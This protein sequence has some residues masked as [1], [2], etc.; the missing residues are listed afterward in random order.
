M[1]PRPGCG[2][3]I[4]WALCG[5]AMAAAQSPP[6]ATGVAQAVP[7]AA[8]MAVRDAQGALTVRAV[9]IAEPLKVDGHLDEAVYS[10]V[11]SISGFIQGEPIAGA[12]ATEKTE[13]WILFDRENFYVSA[14]CWD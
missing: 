9:R 2:V 3:L 1:L 5:P 7:T 11:P 10:E 12:P 6:A 14:R 13:V 8:E 4:L